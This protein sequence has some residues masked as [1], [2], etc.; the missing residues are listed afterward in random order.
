MRK[1]GNWGRPGRSRGGVGGRDGGGESMSRQA[2]KKSMILLS[3]RWEDTG[4]SEEQQDDLIV[5]DPLGL[6]G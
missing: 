2:I 1:R 3:M 6:L 4:G 5:L